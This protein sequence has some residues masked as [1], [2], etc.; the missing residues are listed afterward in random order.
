MMKPYQ[1]LLSGVIA[2]LTSLL[3]TV[4]AFAAEPTFTDVPT[5]SPWYDG[6]EYLAAHSVTVGTGEGRY[7]PDAP[8]TVRQWAV[9]LC[10]LYQKTEAL[11]SPG[12]EFGAACVKEAFQSGWLTA[13]SISAPDTRICRSALYRSA[14]SAVDLPVYAA[15]L[16]PEG[17]ALSSLDNYMRLGMEIGLCTETDSPL[18]LVTRGEAASVLFTLLSSDY[19]ISEPPIL[20]HFPIQNEEGVCMN[21]YLLE[22]QRVPEPILQAFERYGWIYT[23][24]F[25][26]LADLSLKYD[27]T[28]IGAADYS[29]KRI[30]VSEAH[31]TVH[32]FGHFLDCVLG[33][34]SKSY[35][36]YAE[37]ASAT[38][39]FLRDYART[40]CREY[41]ADYFVYW[42]E[43]YD[44]PDKAA[45]M[46]SLTPKTYQYFSALSQNNW[47]L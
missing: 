21:D 25:Q 36:F 35:T 37:E 45:M 22:L 34:P 10:R 27:M 32:E 5:T 15:S 14:F 9:M 11:E 31:A 18:E 29:A 42:L 26:F 43:H 23:I 17:E 12:T 20:S 3:L 46:Q 39:P 38:S 28:C 1:K 13:E 8:I 4:P 7:S 47:G 40:N 44:K 2:L 24:N 6:V 41:F 33:S 30:Y 19:Q 16:Y